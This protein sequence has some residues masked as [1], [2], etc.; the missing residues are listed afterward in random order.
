VLNALDRVG[1]YVMPGDDPEQ[2][3]FERSGSSPFGIKR[4]SRSVD[5]SPMAMRSRHSFL[6]MTPGPNVVMIRKRCAVRPR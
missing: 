5:A 1:S 4:T 2:Y 3:R 6:R